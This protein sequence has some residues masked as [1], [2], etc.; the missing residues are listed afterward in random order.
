MSGDKHFN[1]DKVFL[2]LLVFT[3][4]EVAWGMGGAKI[5]MGKPMLWGGLMFF[6]LLK[7]W[8]IAIY[9]MHLKFEG[10]IIWSLILPTPLLI[11]VIMGY[12]MSDVANDEAPYDHAIGSMQDVDTGEIQPLE[13]IWVDPADH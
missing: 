12:V 9:F 11:L 3:V 8:L 4:L 10:K 1:A 6:A 2:G 5:E 13:E 7:A